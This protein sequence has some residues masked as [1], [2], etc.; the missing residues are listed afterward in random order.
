MTPTEITLAFYKGEGTSMDALV[1][2]VTK[3]RYSH[4]EVSIDGIFWSSSA[5]DG[6][7]RPRRLQP[8]PASWDFVHVA[9]T[10]EEVN[11]ARRVFLTNRGAKYDWLGVFR[12][13]LPFLKPSSSRWFCSEIAAEA[14]GLSDPHKLSPGDLA[15]A[16][17]LQR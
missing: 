1:R 10:P 6:G 12:F 13:L 14:L 2:L 5:R 9:R 15:E 17:G 7:V 16:F 4:I 3:S 11:Q 8:N